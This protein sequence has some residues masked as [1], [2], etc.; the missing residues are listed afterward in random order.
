MSPSSL[1]YTLPAL[2]LSLGL[3]WAQAAQAVAL[4]APVAPAF[5]ADTDLNG[6]TAAARPELAGVVLADV[7]TPFS[8]SGINGMVQSRVV[9]ENVAGTLDFYWRINVTD[10]SSDLGVSTFRLGNFGVANLTDAD[11]RLDG[12]GTAA[13]DFAR[14]FSA[15]AVPDGAVNFSILN[16]VAAGASSRF[17][18]L[19]TNATAFA[20][21]GS[22]DL[23]TT[24]PQQLS[25]VYSTF[26][27]SAVPEPS[28]LVMA[29][30]G[31][32]AL[33]VVLRRA[34]QA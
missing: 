17:F 22:F 23:L 28:S 21:T 6:T 13:P 31:L 11:W 26:A 25:S 12:V 4:T 29:V 14:L 33:G 20:Q 9:R 27:P 15:S 7:L 8:F 16:G 19:H 34:R 24:G 1:R 30:A 10:S 2:A 32:A 3:M 18:F 5:F